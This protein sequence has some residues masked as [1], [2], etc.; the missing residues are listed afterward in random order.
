M[1]QEFRANWTSLYCINPIQ[2]MKWK[3]NECAILYFQQYLILR[4]VSD[5]TS[6]VT[7]VVIT[8]SISPQSNSLMRASQWRVFPIKIRFISRFYI[9][10]S[11]FKFNTPFIQHWHSFINFNIRFNLDSHFIQ[12]QRSLF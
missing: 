6:L 7:E 12:T 10:P 5:L 1:A 11:F 3:L 2:L 9:R 8:G 4:A